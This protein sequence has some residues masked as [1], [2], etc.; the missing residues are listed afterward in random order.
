RRDVMSDLS[1]RATEADARVE[2]GCPCP[3]GPVPF[4]PIGRTPEANVVAAAWIVADRQLESQVLLMVPDIKVADRSVLVGA[5]EQRGPGDLQGTAEGD[6]IGRTPV[7]GQ[8]RL[9]DLR[10]GPDQ[11]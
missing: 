2:R 7:G 3:Q 5:P 10:F 6:R 8:H 11:D 1:R 4:I 9:L